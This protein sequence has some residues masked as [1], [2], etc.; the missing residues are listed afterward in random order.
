MADLYRQAQEDA[1]V[2][3][4]GMAEL[5]G[6]F[7]NYNIGFAITAVAVGYF[8]LRHSQLRDI[9][10]KSIAVAGVFAVLL[11]LGWLIVVAIA[12]VMIAAATLEIAL[13]QKTRK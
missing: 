4:F 8:A 3:L 13:K 6:G 9:N 10:L 12:A 11:Y 2:D 7:Q 1:G 5:V